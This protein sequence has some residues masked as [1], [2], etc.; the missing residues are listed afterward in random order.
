MAPAETTAPSPAPAPSSFAAGR[1]QVQRLLGEGAKK[2]VYLARDERLDRDVA[3]ALIKTEGLD[4]A[5]RTRVAREAQAM[6]RLGDHPHIVTVHDIGEDQGQLYIVSQYMAGGDLEG[7]L[8]EAENRR[9]PIDEALRIAE[10]LCRALEHAH[11]RGVVHRDLKPGNVWLAEDGS[12]R[13]G[14]FGLALSLDRSRI[15]QEGMM[16]GTAAYMPPEQALSGEV[17]ARSDLYALGALLYEMLAGR[18]PFLGDDVVAVISQ[19]INTAPVAPSWHNPEI[20]RALEALMLRLLAKDPSQRPASAAAARRELARVASIGAERVPPEERA[21]ANPLDRLAAGVFV[22]RDRELEQLRDALDDALSGRGRILMLVGE[23]GIGKTRTA[24]ELATYARL[25]SAQV[26]WG[27]CYEGEGAPAYWPWV[28]IIRAYVHDREPGTLLS[29]MGPGAADIAEVVSEVRERLPG[30]PKPPELEPEQARFRLFDSITTFLK[31][32]SNQ[33]PLALI[34]DDLHWA[35]KPSLLLLQFLARELNPSRLLLLGTY[36]DVELGRQH[37]L[38]QTLAELARSELSERVLLRGLTQEDVAR[39]IELTAG[40]SAP[41]ALVQVVYRETEG[42]PFFVHEVVQ[43]LQSDGRLERAEEV[44]SWSLEIPQSVRQVVGQRLSALSE[45]CNR[46]LSIAS[47]IGREFELPV[48]AEVSGLPEDGFLELLDRA[49]DARIISELA[50]A[51]GTYRFSHAL[52]RET[53]YEEIRTA[54]RL[55]LHRRI[56]E[57]IETLY[58]SKL[59]PH[60][61]QLAYHFCEAASG[62]D[63]DKAIEYSMRAAER[64]QR[65]FA[66]EEAAGHYER[67]ISALEAADPVDEPRLCELLLLLGEAQLRSGTL[68]QF[69][70]T[71]RRAMQLARELHSPEQFARAA[72]DLEEFLPIGGTVNQEHVGALEQALSLLGDED[73]ALRADVMVRLALALLWDTSASRREH[74]CRDA[75][76]MTRRLGDRAAVARALSMSNYVIGRRDDPAARL[77]IAE[78]IFPLAEDLNDWRLLNFSHTGKIESLIQLGEGEALDRAIEAYQRF[79]EQLRNTEGIGWA[80]IRRAA[81]VLCQGQLAEAARLTVDGA[82]LCRR[83]DP[84]TAEQVFSAQMFS[85]LRMQGRL[86]E[87]VPGVREGLERFPGN[88]AWRCSLALALAETGRKS[89]ARLEL[90]RL[91]EDDFAFLDHDPFHLVN[92][93]LLASVCAVLGDTQRAAPLYDRLLAYKGRYLALETIVIAGSAARALG[94]L[95]GAMHRWD[96]AVRHFEE[97]IEADKRMLAWAWLAC[98]QC[99]YARTLLD[100]G[101]PG[102]RQKAL[103]LLAEALETC[104]EFRLKGWLNLCLELK[105]R[106]QGVDSGSVETSIEAVAASLGSRRPDLAPHAAPDGT[107]TLMFSDMEGFSAMTER[108]GDRKAH[109]VIRTHNAIVRE[110]LTAHKGHEVELQGDGFLLAFSSPGQGLMCAISIQRAFAAYSEAHPEEPIRVR[111]GLHTGE[112]LRDADKFFGKTVILAARIAAQAHGGEILVSSFLKELTEI[113]GDLRFDAGREVE[114]KGIS[115]R[116]R[117]HAVEWQ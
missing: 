116:Q 73:S 30:L 21:A 108:L 60:L 35:D 44:A 20:P 67:A 71:F 63:L 47:V 54:Q 31:N 33:Q 106:A 94:L 17:D 88:P 19:H 4:E 36:R 62:G 86:E 69:R 24:E 42:N 90:E 84:E 14:D 52:I 75:V 68:P 95:A 34:V 109:E 76:D 77:A 15:T 43:L 48:L 85:L 8:A 103:E 25:R 74:L 11:E 87:T 65:A 16:V 12:A 32:A 59:E 7:H 102:D 3:V 9:L 99:D 18:P 96:A 22:G 105:L 70:Q 6:G 5:G 72:Q 100:R 111:I 107:V 79:T 66:H 82:A 114:L 81:R 113:T 83:V 38:E 53:L 56:A 92:L 55:R 89:E 115:E 98:T 37:P 13:L 28:Q 29:E 110:Q 78:E 49:Q 51:S 64:E 112:V 57:V 45:E 2:R 80:L 1:Y 101:A 26:L 23:P 117:L 10:E 40:Q 58:A 39:F 50:G 41:A 93:S 27:R 61:G 46:I 91:A 104:Q 97:A